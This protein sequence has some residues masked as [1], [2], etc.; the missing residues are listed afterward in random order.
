MGAKRVTIDPDESILACCWSLRLLL[1]QDKWTQERSVRA[2]KVHAV[3][4][5]STLH[6]GPRGV[7]CGRHLVTI[8]GKGYQDRMHNDA[9][10]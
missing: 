6:V 1:D 2:T 3:R 9:G 7:P 8:H 4:S 5:V 10:K